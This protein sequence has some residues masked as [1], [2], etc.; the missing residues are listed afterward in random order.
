MRPQMGLPGGAVVPGV[1]ALVH[2]DGG[3]R[4]VDLLLLRL[5]P[6]AILA[7]LQVLLL[8]T[9][10]V[11]VLLLLVVGLLLL[12]VI[13]MRQLL[14]LKILALLQVLLLLTIPVLLVVVIV[15]RQRLLLKIL[16]RRLLLL[17]TVLVS[18][19]TIEILAE[20]VP[21]DGYL[22]SPCGL[23]RAHSD[24]LVLG[25][26]RRHLRLLIAQH[27]RLSAANSPHGCRRLQL[28]QH[29]APFA[30]FFHDG[31]FMIV[32]TL[33]THSAVGTGMIRLLSRL[34]EGNVDDGRSAVRILNQ[35]RLS[36]LPFGAQKAAEPKDVRCVKLWM[37]VFFAFCLPA[38]PHVGRLLHDLVFLV[39]FLY[40]HRLIVTYMQMRL[41]L[42]LLM[43]LRRLLLLL[44]LCR[45]L[46]LLL[47]L[48]R[49][50][51]LCGQFLLLRRRWLL[52]GLR[53][54]LLLQLLRLLG[55]LLLLM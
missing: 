44:L 7:L 17:L 10:L 26:G 13:V 30:R 1:G 52:L 9:I 22:L 14:L 42:F 50:L 20:T 32:V 48:C 41:V 23:A 4:C 8:L 33:L 29:P 6:L 2:V 54:L 36:H 18:L 37:L 46:L 43:Q 51:L 49:L 12:V 19:L 16:T 39:F 28:P 25:G 45:L 27:L 34:G 3:M 53:L 5:L 24:G 55:R 11:L 31:L 47:L 38:L 15:M 35:L 21:K 40:R